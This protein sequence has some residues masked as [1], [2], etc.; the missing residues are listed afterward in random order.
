MAYVQYIVQHRGA[1][2]HLL[3]E[4]W[5]EAGHL[6]PAYQRH[7]AQVEQAQTSKQTGT[8]C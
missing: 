3:P 8:K 2:P 5:W 6:L 7:P 1:D 4:G